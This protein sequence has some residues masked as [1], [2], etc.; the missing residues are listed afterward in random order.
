MIFIRTWPKIFKIR[1]ETSN[2]ESDRALSEGKNRK[3]IELLN[4]ELGEKVMTENL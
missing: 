2:Y 3:L 4:N 1:F